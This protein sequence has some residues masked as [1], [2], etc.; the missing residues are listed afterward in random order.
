MDTELPADWPYPGV[1]DVEVV[2]PYGLRLTFADGT[3]GQV[4][5]SRWVHR[6]PAGVFERLR[7]PAEFAKVRLLPEWGTIVWPGNVDL[8]PDVLY[9][10]AHGIHLPGID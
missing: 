7:D 4:D 2:P 8:C 5:G 3:S 6:E 10:L 1:T 9:A